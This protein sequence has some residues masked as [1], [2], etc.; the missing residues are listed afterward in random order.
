MLVKRGGM[1]VRGKCNEGNVRTLNLSFVRV[2]ENS[3]KADSK[4][5]FTLREQ[6]MSKNGE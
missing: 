5:K 1:R 4:K 6:N 2:R 3:K